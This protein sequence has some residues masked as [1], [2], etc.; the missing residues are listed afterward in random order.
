[1]DPVKGLL[2]P[3]PTPFSFASYSKEWPL[4]QQ[5]WPYNPGLDNENVNDICLERSGKTLASW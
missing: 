1:M 4:L 3:L 2:K 5:G